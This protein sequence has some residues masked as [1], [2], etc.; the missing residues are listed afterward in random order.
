LAI[1][2]SAIWIALRAAHRAH[3]NIGQVMRYAVATGRADRD[4]SGDLRGALP[5]MK[6]EHF[7]AITD[8]VEV[9][10]LL[11]TIDGFRG[12][13][14]V[15]CA[16]RLAPLV[17]TRPGEL[18]K[19]KWVEIDLE[20]SEWNI[21]TQRMK[22]RKPH[23]VPLSRQAVTNLR[24]LHALTGSR[25]FV[26]PGCDP[27][28]S[29]S[30]AAVNAALRRMGYGVEDLRAGI[31]AVTQRGRAAAAGSAQRA[32]GLPASDAGSEHPFAPSGMQ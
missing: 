18:R 30:E 11:R 17:F 20:K 28:K 19:A 13:F 15:Q 2:A 24:E 26:F 32:G 22:T 16:L 8:P 3:Q 31:R 6:H 23:I 1:S 29:M 9:G 21:S 10:K 7:A 5:P 4:P 12:T 25:A 27:R 14:V